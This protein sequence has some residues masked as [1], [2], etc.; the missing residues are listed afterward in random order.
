[1]NALDVQSRCSHNVAFGK[2][3]LQTILNRDLK[4]ELAYIDSWILI[5]SQQIV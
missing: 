1:M 5:L 4:I 3:N 2:P